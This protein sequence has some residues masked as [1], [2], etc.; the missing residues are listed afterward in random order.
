VRI[1]KLEIVT[2]GNVH[3]F[4]IS[5]NAKDLKDWL[6]ETGDRELVEA[7]PF[8]RIWGVG[9]A[10][11]DAERNRGRWGQNLLGKALMEVRKRVREE[12]V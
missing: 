9:Y 1:D 2:Q 3:K 7:S 12:R 6:L 8:D 5:S 10:E 11:K 4:R